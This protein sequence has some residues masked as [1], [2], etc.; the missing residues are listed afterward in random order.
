MAN[1]KILVKIVTLVKIVEPV[2]ENIVKIT[3]NRIGGL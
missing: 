2:K 3:E 1:C